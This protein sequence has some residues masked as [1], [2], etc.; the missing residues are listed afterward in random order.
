M[1]KISH[2]PT[3][4]KLSTFDVEKFDYNGELIKS[5]RYS[6]TIRKVSTSA[7]ELANFGVQ[8]SQSCLTFELFNILASSTM[9]HMKTALDVSSCFKRSVLSVLLLSHLLFFSPYSSAPYSSAPYSSTFYS[10]VLH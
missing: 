6:S 8:S 5:A 9:N 4:Y 10:S 7:E 2:T 1:P 3:T